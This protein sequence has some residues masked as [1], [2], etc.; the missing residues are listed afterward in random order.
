VVYIDTDY[1]R[2]FGQLS[3]DEYGIGLLRYHPCEFPTL[4][5]F[6]RHG[7]NNRHFEGS[8]AARGLLPLTKRGEIWYDHL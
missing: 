4:F 5:P 3:A 2:Q 6:G 7:I 1:V 8:L